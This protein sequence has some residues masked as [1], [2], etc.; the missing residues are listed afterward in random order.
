MFLGPR[1]L[2]QQ[3]EVLFSNGREA[4]DGALKVLR[5]RV[6]RPAAIALLQLQTPRFQRPTRSFGRRRF[7]H[8]IVGVSAEGVGGED[9]LA[10]GAGEEDE[11]EVEVGLRRPY[12]PVDT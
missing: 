7:V 6:P 12:Q 3:F 4:T 9:G 2:D 8:Q 11:G 10:L 5:Q 1:L